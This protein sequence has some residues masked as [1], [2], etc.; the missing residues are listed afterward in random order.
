MTLLEEARV[1][2]PALEELKGELHRRPELSF[3]EVNTTA[4]IRALLEPLGVEFL[5]LG[6]ETGVAA[7]LRGGKPG[8]T[9][10]LRAGSSNR[11]VPSHFSRQDIC[12]FA[13][14]FNSTSRSLRLTPCLIITAFKL[15]I[16]DKIIGC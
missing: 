10:A 9:V 13:I 2:A 15:S 12:S 16:L 3:H 5:D 7:L 1:L 8:P 4:K 14:R 11:F 6:M